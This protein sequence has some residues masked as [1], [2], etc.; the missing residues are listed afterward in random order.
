MPFAVVAADFNGDG[1]DD[2]AT[3]NVLG[4]VLSVSLGNGDGTFRSP[5]NYGQ[6]VQGFTI[7]T[8]DFNHDGRIDLVV[9]D[10]V[11]L[12]N[13]DG[14]FQVS[15]DSPAPGGGTYVTADLDGDG[16]LDLIAVARVGHSAWQ[17]YGTFL[18]AGTYA[19][20][21]GAQVP[22]QRI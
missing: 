15:L 17:W 12:G 22:P 4:Q 16:N 8:G 10:S 19:G 18:L 9:G 7:I 21:G 20:G 14:T 13:G 2:L 1:K 6:V 3:A 5:V 11:F